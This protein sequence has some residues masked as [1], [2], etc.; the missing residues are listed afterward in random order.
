[1]GE[2]DQPDSK[3]RVLIVDD[4]PLV[5][6]SLARLIQREPDLMACGEA[7]DHLQAMDAVAETEPHMVLVDLTLK[8]SSGLELVK[9]ISKTHPGIKMLVLS[10]HEETMLAERVVR[11][12]AHGYITKNE[13][14]TKIMQA[15]RQVLGGEI[16]WSER[17]A[18]CVA[19]RIAAH[20]GPNRGLPVSVLT[21]REMEV[22]ELIGIGRSTRQIASILHIG[23]STVETYRN[24]IRQKL[25]FRDGTEL[26]Q[27][28]ITLATAKGAEVESSSS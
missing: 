8:N 11:A 23:V 10:M 14:H 26:L 20:N 17:A 15:I 5:R 22:F 12:G 4:H 25:H 2:F 1:M 16:Y 18:T 6:E 21:D 27:H 24:R 9:D 19:S 3:I 13:P 7:E 28:A